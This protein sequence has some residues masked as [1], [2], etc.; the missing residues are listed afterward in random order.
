M[1]A[2]SWK[3]AAIAGSAPSP[4]MSRLKAPASCSSF[5]SSSASQEASVGEAHLLAEGGVEI[6]RHR[7]TRAATW[8]AQLPSG[9]SSL[10][11]VTIGVSPASASTVMTVRGTRPRSRARQGRIPRR[12]RCCTRW[13]SSHRATAAPC[14]ARPSTVVPAPALKALS[15]K[16]SCQPSAIAAERS[17]R[18]ACLDVARQREAGPLEVDVGHLVALQ[19]G[20]QAG[21]GID[22]VVE[23]DL[24]H[25]D[26]GIG[27]LEVGDDGVQRV[28]VAAAV[29]A[30]VKRIS[31]CATAAS[32]EEDKPASGANSGRIWSCRNSPRWSRGLLLVCSSHPD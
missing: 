23:D 30:W 15:M 13:C 26:A 19:L 12:S 10:L 17:R 22:V 20:D 27:G 3:K 4:C 2:A 1:T 7:T 18:I 25:R 24:V 32:G 6:G 29:M 31:V 8:D 14:R 16:P 11:P 9:Q 21:V 5:I 28:G